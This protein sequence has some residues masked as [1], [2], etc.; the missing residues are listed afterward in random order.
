MKSLRSYIPVRVKTFLRFLRHCCHYDKYLQYSYSQEGEDFILR[1]I[2]GD[3]KNGFFIDIG[4]HHPRRFSNTFM[5]YQQGWRG[6]NIDAMPGSMDDFNRDR[7]RDINL[8]IPVLKDRAVLKYY[9][10]NEPALNSFSSEISASR[11][12]NNGYSITNIVDLEGFPLH[13]ILEKYFPEGVSEID[14]MSVDVEGLDLDVLESN[15]WQR[16]RPNIILVELLNCSL[17]NLQNDP[18]YDF[19]TSK[20]YSVFSKCMQTVFFI[21]NEYMSERGIR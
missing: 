1:K 10:F 7:N 9:Q 16:F 12:G 6:I 13:Y 4:A 5:L 3:K 17:S 19:L 14:F 11:N 18:V 8:E 21:K 20:G 2:F 15:D